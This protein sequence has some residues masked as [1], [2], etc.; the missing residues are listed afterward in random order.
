MSSS[1]GG[2]R[3]YGVV[4]NMSVADVR[5]VEFV[6]CRTTSTTCTSKL[7]VSVAGVRVVQFGSNHA[8]L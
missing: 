1:V 8:S 2:V 5:V 4:Y 3:W 7:V 6:T